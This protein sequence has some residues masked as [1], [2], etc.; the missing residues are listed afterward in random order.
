M[1]MYFEVDIVSVE[2]TVCVCMEKNFSEN[3]EKQTA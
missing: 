3:L 2:G 1:K